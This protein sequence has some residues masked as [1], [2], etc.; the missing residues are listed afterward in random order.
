MLPYPLFSAANLIISVPSAR[1]G[2]AAFTVDEET[3]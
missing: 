3:E 1:S 2:Q